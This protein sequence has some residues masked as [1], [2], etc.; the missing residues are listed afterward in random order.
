MKFEDLRK[1]CPVLGIPDLVIFRPKIVEMSNFSIFADSTVWCYM[2]MKPSGNHQDNDVWPRKR[3]KSPIQSFLVWSHLIDFAGFWQNEWHIWKSSEQSHIASKIIQ[4][5]KSPSFQIFTSS[6]IFK[7][8]KSFKFSKFS[9]F[10]SFQ[11][12]KF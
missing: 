2:A 8:F 3:P 9:S 10:Q 6:Q 1:I 5:N 4:S 7:V 11:V 12:F